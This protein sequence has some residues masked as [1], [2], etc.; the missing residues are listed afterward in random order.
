MTNK[1]IELEDRS[2]R[3]NIRIDGIEEKQYETWDRCE[4][5]VQ[6][7][8]KDKLGIED[9]VEIDR[10]DRMKKSGKDRSNNERNSRP[11]TIICRL[12]RFKD[13]QRIIQSSKKLKNTGIF[14]YEDFCKDT[15]DLRKQLWEKV[16]EHRANNKISYLNYRSIVVRN[17]RNTAD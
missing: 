5:K 7:V 17:Q 4:E 8:I 12:L 11:R 10:C 6:K 2:Q 15:M 1:L 9:E 3:N 14:I 16:L 13:K